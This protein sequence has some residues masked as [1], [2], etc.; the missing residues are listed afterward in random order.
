MKKVIFLVVLFPYALSGQVRENFES[1]SLQTWIQGIE[2]HWKADTT[3]AI[4]GAYSLHHIFDNQAAG[5]DCAGISE[6]DLH[7][8]E[9]NSKWR[10]SIRHGVDPSASNNWCVYLMCDVSPGSMASGGSA[11]GIAIGVN[12]TGSDD[13]LRLWKIKKGAASIIMTLPV[14]WQNNIG[15]LA[16]PA[17]EAERS[18]AGQWTLRIFNSSGTLIAEK[19]AYEPELFFPAY[20][21]LNYRYTSTRD[22]LLWFD[23][24]SVDGVFRA[25]NEPPG[26]VSCQPVAANSIRLVLNEAPDADFMSAGNFYAGEENVSPV[27]VLKESPCQFRLIFPGSFPNKKKTLLKIVRI[28]D[29]SGNCISGLITDFM[30]VSPDPGDVI[31]TEIMADPVPALKLPE[32]EYLEI[33]NRSDYTFRMKKWM[34]NVTGQCYL[35]PDCKIDPGEYRVL[36][37]VNDTSLFNIYGSIVGF[38]SF[39]SL[40]DGGRLIWI[41]DSA[42]SLVHGVE[43]SEAWYG[44]RLKSEGGWSLEMI[45]T[46]YPFFDAGNW[47]ASESVTGGSPGKANSVNASNPDNMF[48]GIENVFPTE[49]NTVRLFLSET[50][51]SLLRET[52]VYIDNNKSSAVIPD[53]PLYRSFLVTTPAAMQGGQQYTL[54]IDPDVTDFAGNQIGRLAAGLGL[55]SE[56]AT[57]DVQFNELLFDPLPDCPEY[58]ELYNCSKTVIDA[59]QLY[60]ASINAGSGDTSSLV[61]LSEAQR[62]ILPGQF[63][64]VTIDRSLLIDKFREADWENIFNIQS[65]PSMPAEEGHL[66]LLSRNLKLIDEV[67]YSAEMHS[68]L[69]SGTDGVS[70]EKIRPGMNSSE[71]SSWHSASEYAGWG[72]P[73]KANSVFVNPGNNNDRISLST[74]SVSPDDDGNNDVLVVDINAEGLGNVVS[75]TLFDESGTMVKRLAENF[76]AGGKA[77]V[78]WDATGSDGT[79]VPSGIYII[80]IEMYNEKGKTRSWK[81]VCSVAR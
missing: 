17:L 60:L 35:F 40:T 51:F 9:G 39:P 42:G 64:T 75:V 59:S 15:T 36:C 33:L 61:L 34:L 4:S 74:S 65:M 22:R 66:L 23:N 50:S 18:A 68:P 76:F 29:E 67:I 46:H 72:T 3:A 28:C 63:F 2:G 14:N 16:A 43:Y 20:L 45:D 47:R 10:F 62:C 1:G 49:K 19:S 30:V 55:P 69:L 25:D 13:S 57:G 70:L 48:R 77:S 7:P 11:S 73:G 56:P 41:T 31:I 32:R 38:K 58:I 21:L 24:L 26:V 44:S 71:S 81:R 6:S 5:S 54:S 78:V 53:D 8:A 79:L 37:P 12:I 52:G 27:S 80:L